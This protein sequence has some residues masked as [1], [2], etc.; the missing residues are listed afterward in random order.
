M[1]GNAEMRERGLCTRRKAGSKEGAKPSPGAMKS[2]GKQMSHVA[3]TEYSDCTMC[4]WYEL[5]EWRGQRWPVCHRWGYHLALSSEGSAQG[6]C[7]A[8]E[9]ME[10]FNARQERNALMQKRLRR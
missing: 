9:T 5:C 6:Q 1:P 4:H 10:D 3:D 7:P 8:Y 2:N